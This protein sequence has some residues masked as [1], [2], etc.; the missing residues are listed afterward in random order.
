MLLVSYLLLLFYYLVS[1]Y[2]VLT[3]FR[4]RLKTAYMITLSI[5]L[6]VAVASLIPFFMQLVFIPLTPASVFGVLILAALALNIRAF[7]ASGGKALPL[8]ASR[9]PCRGSVSFPMRSRS[10]PSSRS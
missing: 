5:L 2:G 8:S 3:L 10:W 6:G 1:G 4:L 7:V 9:S